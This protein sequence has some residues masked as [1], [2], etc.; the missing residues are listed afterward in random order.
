MNKEKFVVMKNDQRVSTIV[1]ESAEEA[2]K[3][4]SELI[5]TLSESARTA[6][7]SSISVKQLLLG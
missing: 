6:E 5:Q 3:E 4:K 1:H 2:E 7:S